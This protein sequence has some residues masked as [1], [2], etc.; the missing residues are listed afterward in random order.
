MSEKNINLF[1][2]ACNNL[3]SSLD[4][5]TLRAYGRQ[6]GVF[7]PTEKNKEPLIE[8]IIKIHIGEL[9]PIIPNRRG[10]PVK[11]KT[12]N[13]SIEKEIQKLRIIYL[14]APSEDAKTE[15][16]YGDPD[17]DFKKSYAELKDKRVYLRL[18]DGAASEIDENGERRVH[19]GQLARLN[20]V[21]MLLPLNGMDSDEKVVISEEFI[22]HFDIR[23]GDVV[24]CYC[25][26]AQDF[27]VTT[28]VLKINGA[29]VDNV[30]RINFEERE[31]CYPIHRINVYEKERFASTTSKF[32][33]WISPIGKGQRAIVVSS[34]KAGKTRLLQE[35]VKAATQ[36][37]EELTT[38]VLLVDQSYEAVA[39]YRNIVEK[40]NLAYSTYEDD[41]DRQVFVAD[42]L[43][44]RAK[45]LAECG[46]NVLL[47]V[48]SF[49]ALASA[50]NE[51]DASAGGKMLPCGLENKTLRYLKKYLGTARCFVRGGSLTIL[52]AVSVSTGNP[53]DDYI[54]AEL[55][56]LANLNVR[57]SDALA[58]KRIYPALDL[59][60]VIAQQKD[61]LQ[62][63]TEQDFENYLRTQYLPNSG[64]TVFLEELKAA[65]TY[66]DLIRS[67]CKI[68]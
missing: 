21:S 55:T 23:E 57:L 60:G 56:D 6:V 51:T 8:E 50:Y 46:Q 31:A 43:L 62:T 42:F 54:A 18:E 32:F 19:V 16:V 66:E 61:L 29:S 35:I 53:A 68:K 49:N 14:C 52:G 22:S 36:L 45:S 12:V 17:Y 26:K 47:V 5:G 59:N 63:K 39:E 1:K 41:P 20:S 7:R 48:D 30:C 25:Q 15:P 13:P 34:P 11:N 37:N 38:L 40:D 33:Q 10:A 28:T 9:Q 64:A 67:I 65:K 24:S 58:M 4:I 3:L 44:K 2:M 27:Y